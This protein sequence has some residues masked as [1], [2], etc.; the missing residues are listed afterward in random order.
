VKVLQKRF[1]YN[2]FGIVGQKDQTTLKIG[3]H[4]AMFNKNKC[5]SINYNVWYLTISLVMAFVWVS[6]H[7]IRE[8]IELY[9]ARVK[10]QT[11]PLWNNNNKWFII[12]SSTRWNV[13]L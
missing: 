3:N 10:R 5:E 11:Y 12:P 9:G 1:G 4:V 8:N 2:D 7:K 13:K 6:Q